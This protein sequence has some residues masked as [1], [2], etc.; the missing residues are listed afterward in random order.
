VENNQTYLFVYGTL[1][2][3]MGHPM[4]DRLSAHGDFVG[5]GAFKGRLYL[6]RHYPGAVASAEAGDRVFGE[7]YRLRK[8]EAAFQILD[9]YE[10]CA[11]GSPQPMEYHRKLERVVLNDGSYVT[12]WIY[13]YYRPIRGLPRIVSGRFEIHSTTVN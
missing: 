10:G 11:P 9:D 8:A 1:M 12:A 4:H 2:R 5:E 3:S 7:L 6:V 13:L